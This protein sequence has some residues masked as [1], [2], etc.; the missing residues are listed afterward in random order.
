VALHRQLY[1]VLRDRIVQGG[2]PAGAALPTEELL[3]AQ[4][5][6]SRITVRRALSDLQARGLV[7]RRHGLGT[8]VS[9]HVR[10]PAPRPTL[11]FVDTLRK[12]AAQ[13]EVH[14]IEVGFADAPPHVAALLELGPGERALHALRCRS[15]DGTVVLLTD[16][17]IPGRLGHRITA[18][19]LARRPLYEVLMARGA[20]F[21]RVVQEIGAQAAD[22]RQAALLGAE[23]GGPLLRLVRLI[24]DPEGRPVLHLT[25]TLPAERGSVLMEISGEQIDTLSAGFVVHAR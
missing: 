14:V 5:G 13:T 20:K 19:T 11:S 6:V 2:W 3:G 8:F 17:W 15:I 23:V 9:E 1:L 25:A 21:G 10:A 12:D 22:P 18:A 7:E 16:A 24:H 4:F